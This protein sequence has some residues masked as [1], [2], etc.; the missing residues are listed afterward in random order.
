MF[1]T[2]PPRLIPQVYQHLLGIG[3]AMVSDCAR[4]EQER[5]A[6]SG[7]SLLEMSPFIVPFQ[8]HLAR[9]ALKLQP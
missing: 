4:A 9:D 6:I 1:W 5:C 2:Y 7:Q 3:S 8:G